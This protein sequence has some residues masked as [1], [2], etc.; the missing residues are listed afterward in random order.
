MLVPMVVSTASDRD[1]KVGRVSEEACES[2]GCEDISYPLWARSAAV[3]TSTV[4]VRLCYLL[5]FRSSLGI[6][7]PQLAHFG[8]VVLEGWK[9]TR[10]RYELLL[11]SLDEVARDGR[12][13]EL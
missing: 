1:S 6:D 5:Q 9:G 2:G 3:Y 11:K 8:G 10:E 7:F 12:F 4:L 13:L